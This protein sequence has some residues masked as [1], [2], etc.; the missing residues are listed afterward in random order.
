MMVDGTDDDDDDDDDE[1]DD[2]RYLTRLKTF[3]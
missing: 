1:D 2:L 3:P